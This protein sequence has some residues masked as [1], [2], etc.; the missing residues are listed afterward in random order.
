[1]TTRSLDG[2]WH[3]SYAPYRPGPSAPDA[4]ARTDL[5]TIPAQVPGCVE[6]D[7]VAAGRLPPLEIGTNVWNT[8]AFE[9]C[10]WWY[11][12][13]FRAPVRAVGERLELVFGGIDC[14]ATVWVDGRE[15]GRADNMLIPWRFDVS[16][17]SADEDHELA[18]HITPAVAAGRAHE[19][20][21]ASTAMPMTYA[22]LRVR[23]A[24]HM[25]GWD[26]MPRL[27]S[28][29][30]WRSVAL[31]VVPSTRVRLCYVATLSVDVARR[32]A[33][34]LVDWDVASDRLDLSGLSIAV[35]I[36]QDGRE[37]HAA[38]QPMLDAHGRRYIDLA[39]VA[40]WWPRGY[41]G[42]ELLGISIEV[43]DPDGMVLA[44]H[45]QTAGVRTIELRRTDITTAEQ[46]GDFRFVVNGVPIFVRGTN[47]V[48]LDA[49][50]AR[51]GQHLAST[52]AMLA[53]LNCTMVRCW[54]GNVYESDAFYEYC[55]ANGILVWQDFAMACAIYPQDEEFV[56]RMRRE[57]KA[58]VVRL[59]NH[60]CL[61][62]WAGDN[63]CDE[64]HTWAALGSDPNHDRITRGALPATIRALDPLRPY[65]PSSP[66]RSPAVIAAGGHSHLQPEQH[67]WGP[68]G[69]WR[70]PFYRDST[71][72]FVSEIGYHGCPDRRSLETM[73]AP[74]EVWPW[75]G[76]ASWRAKQVCPMPDATD[77][78]Y[79]LPLMARQIGFLFGAEPSELDDFALASQATQAE[80]L[81]S[82]VEW[83]RLRKWR[84]TGMLWW[85]L[86]DGWPIISDAVVDYYG[87]KKLAYG[88]LQRAQADVCAMVDD[89]VDGRHRVA[90]AN[91]TRTAVD[92][93]VTITDADSGTR[94][95]ETRIAIPA[96]GLV[97]LGTLAEPATPG[98][99]HIAVAHAGGVERNHRIAGPR[100][101]ALADF[102]RWLPMMGFAADVGPQAQLASAG[103]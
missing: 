19:I 40:L 7:L 78:D 3:L 99:W 25:Y 62:L 65:L 74:G 70:D 88:Y 17:L 76:N 89:A 92:V 36:R 10:E 52:L 98:L 21:A 66:Y 48:P 63:E 11:Q 38:R 95:L 56:A 79:R 13:R 24:P 58:V 53:E 69:D 33:R 1:M 83:A 35:S 50:H 9:G 84:C 77:W 23:K 12:R 100:P 14:I 15:V 4:S 31:E 49:L 81:K 41:G 32:A 91:D 73:M 96:G 82:F 46:P 61:A 59:R 80:A 27:V 6:L 16:Q 86:R 22:S 71:A 64:S 54:G 47:W 85:N 20:P 97:E 2:A 75:R 90:V 55:D 28:A 5:A 103:G 45:E 44:R 72:H 39:E 26:I 57:A 101:I 87:R 102:L 42:Q 51:D 43:L 37:L 8:L 34:L 67:L 29:G 68:R 18:V 60:P 30:L 93:T 94:L